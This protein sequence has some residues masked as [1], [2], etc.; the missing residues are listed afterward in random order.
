[1]SDAIREI[2]EKWRQ[3][4]REQARLQQAAQQHNGMF[5]VLLW[6]A[7]IASRRLRLGLNVI[8]L[9]LLFGSILA[10]TAIADPDARVG[11]MVGVCIGVLLAGVWVAVTVGAA[12]AAQ[13]W[14]RSPGEGQRN[15]SGGSASRDR[16][17]HRKARFA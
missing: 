17:R 11:G 14:Q 2:S 13:P 16:D 6:S 12:L 15:G 10:V 7:L 5:G 1:M 8:A 9:V 4:V 3:R